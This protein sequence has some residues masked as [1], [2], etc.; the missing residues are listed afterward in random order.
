[1]S[2]SAKTVVIVGAAILTVLLLATG[3][4]RILLAFGCGAYAF[5][6]YKKRGHSASSVVAEIAAI[7]LLVSG[8]GGLASGTPAAAPSSQAVVTASPT[9]TPTE[10]SEPSP[11]PSE[12]TTSSEATPSETQADIPQAVTVAGG[13]DA[14][15]VLGKLAVKG[16][17][18]KT[19]YSR[20]EFG[21]AWMDVDHNGCDTRNDILGRDLSG[22]TTKA[23][24][25]GCV[26]LTGTLVS[27]YTGAAIAF[28]R[29]QGT[30]EQVPIDH[31]VALSDAWQKGAQQ[32]SLGQRE[33]L[34]NDPLNLLAVD[35]ASNTQKSDGDAAT[36][37]PSN[38][39]YCCEYVARQIGVKAR[40]GLWVTASEKSAMTS[41]LAGCP[42][43]K[44]PN[45][46]TA[47]AVA[48]A[49]PAA[50]RATTKAPAAPAPQKT[51]APAPQRQPAAPAPA[52][53]QQGV[54]YKNCTEARNAGAA[55]IMRGEPGYAPRL[56]RDN[57]GV[58]CE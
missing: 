23:G 25:H 41:V 52:P 44:V 5:W 46:G 4:G 28:Q 53:A 34:A 11:T 14:A 17:A 45:A 50:P 38:K 55:P 10:T 9:P 51:A 21:P 35:R 30:S 49:Q 26:V 20:D 47:P 18:P 29:G 15:T 8:A 22:T 58:A 27:P 19:G 37:L 56:D 57:D 3:V 31:V 36:W 48:A 54:Y 16:R 43:Q 1:M 12:E 13:E 2:K 39:S 7:L 33:A 24:T 32:L 40:Y 6:A 42:G